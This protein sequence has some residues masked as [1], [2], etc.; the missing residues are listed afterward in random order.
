VVLIEGVPNAP[1]NA[2]RGAINVHVA[3]KVHA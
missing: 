3:A 1:L 2:L